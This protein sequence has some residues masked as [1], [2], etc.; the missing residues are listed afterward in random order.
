MAILQYSRRK[1]DAKIE[2][3][4]TDNSSKE[5]SAADVRSI[6]KD[7]VTQSTYGPVLIY[8]G[9]L[10]RKPVGS[11]AI[12]PKDWYFN[13]KY[14]TEQIETNPTSSNNP[15]QLSTVSVPNSV[16]GNFNYYFGNKNDGNGYLH[17]NYDVLGNVI[18]KFIV[19]EAGSGLTVGNTFN[20]PVQSNTVVLTY[21]GVI[22]QNGFSGIDHRFIISTNGNVPTA[23]SNPFIRNHV[24]GNTLFVS[25]GT[26]DNVTGTNEFRMLSDG[27]DWVYI[28]RLTL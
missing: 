8:A 16:D 21:N 12:P 25:N 4:I 14:F 28:Y 15:L 26:F 19:V 23:G 24:K 3:L 9:K 5:I 1:I 11:N 10:K 6:I 27:E 17:V 22:G 13:V 20:L 2:E 7:Y 18:T